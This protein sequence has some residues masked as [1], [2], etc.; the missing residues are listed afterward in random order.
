MF[1][2]DIPTYGMVRIGG[3]R[4]ELVATVYHLI[5]ADVV[6]LTTMVYLTI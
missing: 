3:S 2:L 1:T 6:T 5:N 4:P